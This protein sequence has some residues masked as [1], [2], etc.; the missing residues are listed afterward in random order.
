MPQTH[1]EVYMSLAWLLVNNHGS[2]R[3]AARAEN[4]GS[5]KGVTRE[6]IRSVVRGYYILFCNSHQFVISSFFLAAGDARAGPRPGAPSGGVTARHPTGETAAILPGTSGHTGGGHRHG[7]R[8][9]HTVRRTSR[10]LQSDAEAL[11]RHQ[12]ES[13][14]EA[15]LCLL[16]CEGG[17]HLVVVF[18]IIVSSMFIGLSRPCDLARE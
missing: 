13:Q 12:N 1:I 5:E 7:R 3:H 4:C 6:N 15:L 14:Y 16:N 17:R 10:R 2:Q 9:G 18:T 11:R 8:Q